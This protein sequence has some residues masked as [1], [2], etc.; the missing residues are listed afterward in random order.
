MSHAASR[1]PACQLYMYDHRQPSCGV[2][3]VFFSLDTVDPM[4]DTSAA[5][6]PQWTVLLVRLLKSAVLWTGRKH[7]E[8]QSRSLGTRILRF[9]RETKLTKTVQLIMICMKYWGNISTSVPPLQVFGGG[10][11]PAVP[12]SL[13]QWPPFPRYSDEKSTNRRFFRTQSCLRA[14]SEW[15]AY[16]MCTDVNYNGRTSVSDYFCCNIRPEGLL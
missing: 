3:T 14:H 7:G 4:T 2:N 13:R 9:N 15:S 16:I 6:Q 1:V 11:L 5:H 8:L 10:A 12:L